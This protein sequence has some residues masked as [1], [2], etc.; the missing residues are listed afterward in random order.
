MLNKQNLLR[1]Q[2]RLGTVPVTYNR[3]FVSNSPG[4]IVKFFRHFDVDSSLK[5]A[6]VSLKHALIR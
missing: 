6:R 5:L 1:A 3:Q 4:K 2:L